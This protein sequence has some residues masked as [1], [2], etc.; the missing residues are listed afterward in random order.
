MRL[1][2]RPFRKRESSR[3]TLYAP[4][5]QPALKTAAGRALPVRWSGYHYSVPYALVNQQVGVHLDRGDA[6]G[7]PRRSASDFLARSSPT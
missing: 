2:Q 6:R 3:A 7:S 4:L 1:N 5:D